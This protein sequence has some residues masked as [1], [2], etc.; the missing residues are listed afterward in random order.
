MFLVRLDAAASQAFTVGQFERSFEWKIEI[1][2]VEDLENY[3]MLVI[4]FLSE[5]HR[6]RCRYAILCKV[7]N[8]KKNIVQ[9]LVRDPPTE[10]QKL[11][12]VSTVT[13]KSFGESVIWRQGTIYLEWRKREGELFKVT[14]CFVFLSVLF[15][16][17]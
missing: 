5:T 16:F 10:R 2:L 13:L 8:S 1:T 7:Q 11:R 9:N 4:L 17:C 15:L 6:F 3:Q 12:L 14:V